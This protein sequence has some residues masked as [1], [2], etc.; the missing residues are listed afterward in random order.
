M[1]KKNVMLQPTDIV[2]LKFIWKWKL[3]T[4]EILHEVFHKKMEGSASWGFVLRL[5]RLE[6]AGFIKQQLITWPTSGQAWVLGDKG[7]QVVKARLP[8][9]SEN[10]YK[11]ENPDHDLIVHACH[12]AP[13]LIH[14]LKDVQSFTEQELRRYHPSVAPQF[15]P[16]LFKHRPDGFW[17]LTKNDNQLIALEVELSVKAATRYAETIR[18]YARPRNI[19]SVLWVVEDISIA[20]SIWQQTAEVGNSKAELHNFVLL[21]DFLDKSLDAN[22]FF[23][24]Y[25]GHKVWS[26][27]SSDTPH[28]GHISP[29]YAPHKKSLRD[30]L[31]ATV[32]PKVTRTY[33]NKK[34][35]KKSDCIP[36]ISTQCPITVAQSSNKENLYVQ[37]T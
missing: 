8:E 6:R 34:M 32:Y 1:K 5:N 36:P 7:F 16:E 4:S 35:Q 9:L 21:A 37:D 18:Q 25:R 27:F 10:G 33:Q 17:Q 2:I 11:S 22:V 28:K 14:Q 12:F 24:T 15:F 31:N 20:K 13:V 29:T 30:Y 23:G 26:L 19:K 3:S